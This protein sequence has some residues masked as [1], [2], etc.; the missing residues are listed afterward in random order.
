MT[1]ARTTPAASLRPDGLPVPADDFEAA[2]VDFIVDLFEAYPTWGTAVGYHRV[3]DRWPDLSEAGRSTR[4]AMLDRHAD[5]LA[6]FEEAGLRAEHRVDRLILLDEIEK[7]RFGEAVLRE[8]AWDP[9]VLVYLMGSGLF[10]LIS[11]AYA[12]WPE[13][14]ASFLARIR[15]LPRLADQALAGLTGLPERPV[16]RLQLETAREQ[17]AGVAEVIDLGLAE[18]RRQAADGEGVELVEALEPAAS[19]ARDALER[20]RDG[21]E[22]EVGPRAAGDGRLGP[23]LFARKL[24]LTLGSDISPDELRRRAWADYHAVRAEM[25]R[26]AREAW[27]HFLPDEPLPEVAPGDERAASVLVKRVL[28]AI[29]AQH[30]Q[31]AEL[32][33][34]C[35]A[36][37]E[38]ISAFCRERGVISLPDEPLEI[39]WTPQFMRAY[40]RAFLDSPGS[41]DRG[42][43]S[44]FWITPPDEALGPEAVESYLREDNDR[45]LRDLCIHEGI[46]GH[47]LQL[48]ASNQCA[49]LARTVFVSG[50]FAEGWAV[51]VTQVML[52]LGYAADDPGFA[53]T[54]WKLYLRA[55]I[56]A[57]LDVEI[58]TG[59]MTEAEALELMVGGACQEQD[60][61]R[62]KW[63]RARISATQLST[64]YVGSVQMWELEMD[65]RRRAAIASGA[66]AAAVPDQVIAGGIGRLT[67]LRPARPPRGRHRPWLARH[68][69]ARPPARR[70]VVSNDE[71][72]VSELR[73]AS[74]V[75]RPDTA[76]PRETTPE[77]APPTPAELLAVERHLAMLP[78]FEGA[79]HVED[80][81]LEALFVRGP[82]GE[83]DLSYA[84][85][86]RWSVEAWPSRLAAVRERMRGDGL[87]PSLLWCEPLDRPIGL[88]REL[89][90]HGW[91]RAFGETVMWVGHA[92]VV[93][94]L[95]PRL[96]I[97]AVQEHSLPV[98]E[99]LETDI[100]GLDRSQAER[101]RPAVATALA[102]GRVRAWV[103]W[104]ADEPVAVARLSQG[105]GVA[106]LH[107]IGVVEGH[108][109]Q[110]FGT[111]I[112]TIA[113]R[114][115]LALGNRIVWLSVSELDPVAT[116]VYAR[117]GFAPLLTWSRWLVTDDASPAS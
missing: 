2:V 111:L 78:T 44:H 94:H 36:E 6:A 23:D 72:V 35:A 73:P 95:D 32:L 107:G 21:L 98:H 18:A 76:R 49:S 54:H 55:V 53:L 51:Y 77:V 10:G 84:A 112:T 66:D 24:R 87:W 91:S 89:P 45:M 81:E 68:Q 102:S 99:A 96:R 114:A 1:P 85:M 97:E 25:T 62:G 42:Q 43:R 108:R 109:R 19:E 46:P 5:R 58:H 41:L 67:G 50:L 11:R 90:R 7:A 105:D 39:T 57:I 47:Y 17:A 103:V 86:P 116:G 110:G 92:S 100:F 16:G 27:S 83:P 71:S 106:A 75:Q 93:P 61:A 64:Y 31:P 38:R 22:R 60:E 69:V 13:R 88:A 74:P 70:G 63:L 34:F 79:S 12:P 4:L 113:T 65:A 117:L 80:A 28:D 3:D 104:L 20:F 40:G 82:G 33:A 115:G 14:G 56:N 8:E 101:R 26:L 30:Q 9:L 52:D 48:A 59:G 29:A 15:G 37:I